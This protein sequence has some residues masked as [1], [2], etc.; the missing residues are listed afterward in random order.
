MEIPNTEKCS[1]FFYKI[2]N[3]VTKWQYEVLAHDLIIFR[4]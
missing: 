2:F 3:S 1:G 4:S